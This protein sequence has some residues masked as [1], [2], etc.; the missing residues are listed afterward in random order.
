MKTRLLRQFALAA[1]ISATACGDDKPVKPIV[2]VYDV[3]GLVSEAGQGGGSMLGLSMDSSRPLTMLDVTR[4]LKKAAEDPAVKAVVMDADG[5]QMDLSQIL[6]IRRQLLAARKAGKDVWIY[7]EH[8]SNGIAVL[9]S[10]ANHFTLLPEADC[11]FHGISSESMYFKDLLDKVG[12]KADVIHIGDFK[13]YGETYY[14]S[15][16]SDQAKEQQE[17]LIDSIY[18]QLVA[19]VAEGR[20][21]DAGKVRAVIDDGAMDPAGI[22][23][24]GVAD[25]LMFRTDFVKK[26]RETYGKDAKFDREYELPDLDGPEMTGMMDVFK[27]AFSGSKS[28]RN[29]KDFVAVVALDGDITDESIAP[30]RTQILKLVKDPKAKALV[31]RVN[32]PGGSAMASDVLWEATDEWK[33]T[34]RPFVVSMGGVAA[35]GGYYVSA[36]ADRIFAENGTITGSIGVVG[37]K[38]VI[39]GAMEKLGIT[40]HNTQR[41]KN[42]GVNTMTRGFS[43][44]EARI[45]RESML[46][47]YATFKKRVSDGRGK[48]LKGDLE[49]LAGGRVYSGAQALEIGLV[50]EIGGLHEAIAHA[51]TA[52]KLAAPEVKLLPEPKSGLEGMF[53]KPEKKKDDEIIRASVKS[54]AASQLRAALMNAGL[55]DSL[56]LSA[57]VAVARLIARMEAFEKPQVLMIAPDIELR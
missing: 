8:L 9:G 56:P 16:P 31:L 7:T 33:A 10:A 14:R 36:G 57:R 30:V 22:V 46:K 49:P 50:D 24:A 4:S 13:S 5:A 23:K 39:G 27:L 21:L 6:E 25:H 34:G 19:A 45:M 28:T 51:T 55:T 53:A 42:A 44:E 18:Q 26:L 38:F 12:V 41:G 40:S 15:G 52:A 37:M 29:L 48:A 1:W 11:S 3:E 47:T 32:S 43:E 20:H 35:S 2:A 17:K 54:G